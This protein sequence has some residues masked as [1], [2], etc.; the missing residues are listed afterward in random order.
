MTAAARVA[1]VAVAAIVRK[2]TDRFIF[3]ARPTASFGALVQLVMRTIAPSLVSWVCK[4]ATWRIN[5]MSVLQ[6]L[7]FFVFATFSLFATSAVAQKHSPES[8]YLQHC[9]GCHHVDGSGLPPEVPNL[10]SGIGYLLETPAGRD[11]MLRVPGV[12]S[13]PISAEEMTELL[14]WMITKFYPDRSDFKPISIE[15]TLAGR[16]KPLYDPLKLRA[17]LFPDL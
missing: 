9:A 2:V 17:E 11:F 7:A 10:G 13:T 6:K 4:T 15:E 5:S 14:N 8:N 16:A 3:Q 1:V 12:T